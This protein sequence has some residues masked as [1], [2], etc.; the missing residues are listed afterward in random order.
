MTDTET[1]SLATFGDQKRRTP[2]FTKILLQFPTNNGSI[3]DITACV[4]P[5]IT[6]P[7]RKIAIDTTKHPS[8]H[9]FPLAEPLTH[10]DE[11]LHID[12][13]IGLDHYYDIIGS[14]RLVYPDG[15]LLLD[16]TLGF[17]R[18][19][20]VTTEAPPSVS[21]GQSCLVH[22]PNPYQDPDFDLKRFWSVEDLGKFDDREVDDLALQQFKE[23]IRFEEGRYEVRWPWRD[24]HDILPSNYGLA[25]GRLNSLLKRLS[26]KPNLLNQYDTVISDQLKKGIIEPAPVVPTS[27]HTHYLPHHCV[28]KPSHNTTKVRVVYDASAKASKQSPSLNDCLLSG[29]NL[30]PDLCGVLLRF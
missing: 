14:D 23:N 27:P 15:L 6:S 13:L 9:D 8:L 2:E 30:V 12:I 1:I 21:E 11:R 29:P 28:V 20:K 5:H 22:Q 18:A 4:T 17:I 19:G 24:D 10:T 25:I 7:I 26:T 3:Q 16:S